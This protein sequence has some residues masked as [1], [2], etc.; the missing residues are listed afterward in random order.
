[1]STDFW[2]GVMAGGLVCSAI[3]VWLLYRRLRMLR[4]AAR[5]KNAKRFTVTVLDEWA[6]FDV[7]VD[8]APDARDAGHIDRH[9]DTI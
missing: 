7:T 1:M 4:R 3:Q 6:T 9:S 2:L 5:S 8:Y